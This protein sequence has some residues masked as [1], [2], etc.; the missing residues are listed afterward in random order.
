MHGVPQ[1]RPGAEGSGGG[2]DGAGEVPGWRSE[3]GPHPPTPPAAP[4]PPGCREA[5]RQSQPRAWA[6]PSTSYVTGSADAMGGASPSCLLPTSLSPSEGRSLDWEGGP[7][8]RSLT[9]RRNRQGEAQVAAEDS[10]R[11]PVAR[12]G[13]CPAPPGEEGAHPGPSLCPEQASEGRPP[14]RC[15]GAD[16]VLRPRRRPGPGPSA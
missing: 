16:R 1:H 2:S 15:P 14:A 9:D 3:A 7:S 10:R 8:T 5:A 6:M 11:K 4:A 13:L 12:S